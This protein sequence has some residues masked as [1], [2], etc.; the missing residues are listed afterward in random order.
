MN[1]DELKRRLGQILAEE[2]GPGS[3]WKTVAAL[4]AQLVADYG[5]GL[6]STAK[7]YLASEELR[8]ADAVFAHAQ[9]SELVDYL[10]TGD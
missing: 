4:S 10:R 2:E 6:P 3:D 1:S 7:S 8:R 9:R 5:P